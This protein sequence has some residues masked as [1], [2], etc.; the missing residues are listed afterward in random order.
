MNP[1]VVTL[2]GN[3]GDSGVFKWLEGFDGAG[4][5]AGEDLA[6]MEEVTGDQDK[7]DLFGNGVS[8]NAAEHVEKVFVAFSF[9]SSSAV[10]FAEMDVGGVNEGK[11]RAPPKPGFLLPSVRVP[12]GTFFCG[13][14]RGSFYLRPQ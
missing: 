10:G 7:I 14:T 3:A 11:D 1:V 12:V 9:I 6:G 13:T 4:K 2:H 8:Y 5:S